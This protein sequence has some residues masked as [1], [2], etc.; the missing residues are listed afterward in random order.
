MTM[1]KAQTLLNVGIDREWAKLLLD[2]PFVSS[3]Y[4]VTGLPVLLGGLRL[5]APMLTTTT[6]TNEDRHRYFEPP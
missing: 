2:Q 4:T 6:T 5:V 3:K 1:P